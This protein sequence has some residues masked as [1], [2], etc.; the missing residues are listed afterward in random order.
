MLA[1]VVNQFPRQVDAYFLR[2][3]SGLA[4]RGL[5][6]T[7]YSLLPAPRG[8]KVHAGVQRLLDRTVYPPAPGALLGAALAGALRSPAR[9]T[10][11]VARVVWGHRSMPT[12]LAKSLAIVPQSL[13]FAS[14]MQR[15]GVRHLHAN[16]ATYPATA[17][18]LISRLTGI[19]FSFSGH[20]TD[21]FVHRAMLAEKIAAARFVITCTEYNRG[22]LCDIAP[23]H[24]ARIRTIYHGVD[25][26]RFAANG[27]SRQPDLLLSVG[28]LRACKGFDDL[29]RA[30]AVLR[31]RGRR[32][33][34]EIIGEG[35]DRPILER[36]VR[37][38][39]LTDRVR[40]P[41]YLPQ[42]EVIPAYH[43]AAAVVLPAHLEDHFGI[44][45][46]LIEGFAAG[47]PAIC[48]ELPSLGE[49][50]EAEKSG[51]FV[52]ERDPAGLADAIER[53]LA[54]PGRAASFAAAGYRRVAERF[55][56]ER[57]VDELAHLL[58]AA[59]ERRL[60]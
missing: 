48:T 40:L 8:W 19:P 2:E 42:E 5:D 1:F 14:D 50:V 15:R 45:N 27:T 60:A 36:L 53:L 49:L 22:Y 29:L 57:T 44:P 43:R 21:I 23:D 18:M 38:L 58:G 10:G 52:R 59:V 12:A 20:A 11:G 4:D 41:G 33:V 54:D 7:I 6:F 13:A 32:V 9:C 31:D 28:T 35:E 56:M 37:E 24:A 17:A 3:L 25:L 39:Q 47:A 34:L 55:D 30:I 16:W 51:L 26:P 46:I